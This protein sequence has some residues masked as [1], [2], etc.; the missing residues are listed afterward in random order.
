MHDFKYIL[1][2]DKESLEFAG[3][4]A[5]LTAIV[6]RIINVI[7]ARTYRANRGAAR[8]F[9]QVLTV[10]VMDPDSPVWDHTTNV[11]GNVTDVTAVFARRRK[12]EE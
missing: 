11:A 6:V 4:T 3:T 12:E 1:T 2:K 7:Y 8:T 9:R 10:A 5:E